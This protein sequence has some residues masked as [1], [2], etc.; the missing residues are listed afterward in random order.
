MTQTEADI[1]KR[2]GKRVYVII[3]ATAPR[4]PSAAAAVP[5]SC[6][7][8]LPEKR[9]K[10]KNFHRNWSFAGLNERR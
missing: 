8:S 10:K 6:F 1:I 2:A 3:C 7:T 4:G 9:K 5:S